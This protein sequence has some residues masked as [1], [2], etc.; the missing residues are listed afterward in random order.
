[1]RADGDWPGAAL[2][3]APGAAHSTGRVRGFA[4]RDPAPK[5][6]HPPHSSAASTPPLPRPIRDP[7]IRCVSV[8]I[9]LS[10]NKTP[11]LRKSDRLRRGEDGRQ[12]IRENWGRAA[13]VVCGLD[14]DLRQR[15]V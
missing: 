4:G 13:G 5:L 6:I 7:R 15:Q 1:M 14:R 12:A 11:I 9:R 2:V 3:C 10:E 8:L